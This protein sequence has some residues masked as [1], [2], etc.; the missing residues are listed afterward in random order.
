MGDA[1]THFAANISTSTLKN[2]H[3]AQVGGIFSKN[4]GEKLD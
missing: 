1:A 3:I 4:P 2:R